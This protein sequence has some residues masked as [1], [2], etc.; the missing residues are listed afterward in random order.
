MTTRVLNSST[1]IGA[2]LA[3]FGLVAVA[4]S[5]AINPDPDGGW[6]ARIF[7]L[8]GSGALVVLGVVEC[9]KG[10]S[11][12]APATT[13]KEEGSIL[14][15]IFSLLVLSLAYVWLMGKLGYLISTGIAAVLVLMI[16]GVRNPIGLL[17]AAIV[18]PAIYHLIFFVMLGVYPPYGEWFDLL[19]VIQGN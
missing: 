10:L 12:S 3:I 8:V 6:G 2:G 4:A 15:R 16:F 7:P 17:I 13:P 19:D 1:V 14:P 9:V 11:S 5:M 18:C